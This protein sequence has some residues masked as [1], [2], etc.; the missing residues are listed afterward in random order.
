MSPLSDSRRVVRRVAL[1]HLAVRPTRNLVKF[2]LIDL[3]AEDARRLGG[4]P[5]PERMRLVAVD[6]D[7]AHH[8][9]ADAVV[10]LAERGDLVVRARVLGAEL[11]AREAD[12]DQALVAVVLPELLEA[13]ELRREAALARGVDDQ[14]H[15]AALARELR[16]LAGRSSRPRSRR[17]FR[18]RSWPWSSSAMSRSRRMVAPSRRAQRVQRPGASAASRAP[19]TISAPP[20]GERER[21]RAA[22]EGDRRERREHHLGEHD[23]RGPVRRQSRRAV[24]QRRG[25][26]RGRRRVSA[27]GQQP[28][29]PAARGG[30]RGPRRSR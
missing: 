7:L 9:K 25:C 18:L 29:R 22:A 12:H 14:Q 27:A 15:L 23:D 2:H 13:G 19:A 30:G 3:G 24:L 5:L 16:R 17:C 20:S 26:R 21:Q 6:V 11:V 4:E 28:A 8:R 1:D 10:E